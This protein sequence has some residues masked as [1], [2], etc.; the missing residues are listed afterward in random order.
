MS[1]KNIFKSNRLIIF[2]GSSPEVTYNSVWA[3]RNTNGL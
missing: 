2:S 1:A 3:L